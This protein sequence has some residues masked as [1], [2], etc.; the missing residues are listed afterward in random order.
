MQEQG[1]D[2]LISVMEML[3]DTQELLELG[4]CDAEEDD[5]DEC[6]A[7]M[8]AMAGITDSYA[9]LQAQ[10]SGSQGQRDTWRA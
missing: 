9:V 4:E 1:V 8:V 10:Y 2:S 5:A 3:V 7:Q 6:A